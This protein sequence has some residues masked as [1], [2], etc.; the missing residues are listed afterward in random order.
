MKSETRRIISTKFLNQ[1]Y[2]TGIKKLWEP[3]KVIAA[4]AK[5]YNTIAGM[6]RQLVHDQ[7]PAS[8]EGSGRAVL[9]QLSSIRL[10]PRRPRK[11]AEEN[12]V[13]PLLPSLS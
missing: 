10:K 9:G 5:K 6:A 8:A 4:G 11:L 13:P 1:G 7:N 12:A 2:F 3:E